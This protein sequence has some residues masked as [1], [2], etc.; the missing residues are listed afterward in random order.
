M[1]LT[2][3]EASADQMIAKGS[4]LSLSLRIITIIF[5]DSHFKTEFYRCTFVP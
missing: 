3:P 5:H 2:I 1:I 4:A